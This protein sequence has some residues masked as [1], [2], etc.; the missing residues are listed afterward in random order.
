MNAYMRY[1]L[2]RSSEERAKREVNVNA[3]SKQIALE[4]K[5]LA[6]EKKDYYFQ[7]H[8]IRRR[9]WDALYVEYELLSNKRKILTPYSRFIKKRYLQYSKEY[10]NLSSMEVTK[11]ANEDWK[12]LSTREKDRLKEEFDAERNDQTLDIDRSDQLAQYLDRLERYQ[13]VISEDKEKILRKYGLTAEN[14]A[15]QK[16]ESRNKKIEMKRF[17]KE[18]RENAAREDKKRYRESVKQKIFEEKERLRRIK[19][20]QR[21]QEKEALRAEREKAKAE[22]VAQKQLQAMLK[23]L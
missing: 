4:W 6:A 20:E 21:L 9:E 23:E 2:E 7:M 22:A 5:Q 19:E 13:E 3:L 10:K 11:L 12:A 16:E 17:L 18:E 1:F 15:R 14:K 8:E